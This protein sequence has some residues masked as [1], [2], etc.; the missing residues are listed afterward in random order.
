MK[1][2]N[3]WNYDDINNYL[4]VV[5]GGF[6]PSVVDAVAVMVVVVGCADDVVIKVGGK[7]F[8]WSLTSEQFKSYKS[9]IFLSFYSH[10][11]L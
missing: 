8:N 4:R 9:F 11:Q 10:E 3:S 2:K 1:T 6:A 7:G 5:V